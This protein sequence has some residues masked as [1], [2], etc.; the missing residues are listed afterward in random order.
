MKTVH[1][2]IP[3]AGL[4]KLPSIPQIA[5][6]KAKPRAKVASSFSPGLA[7]G[8]GVQACPGWLYPWGGEGHCTLWPLTAW[9]GLAGDGDGGGEGCWQTPLSS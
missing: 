9:M 7:S 5:K 4:S 1:E 3:L 8:L 6:V 2:R